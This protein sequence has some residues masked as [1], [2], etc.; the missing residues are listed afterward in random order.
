MRNR[1]SVTFLKN[2][3][4]PMGRSQL[5][6]TCFCQ[7]LALLICRPCMKTETTR[8]LEISGV[9]THKNVLNTSSKPL[10]KP[11]RLALICLT[12]KMSCH[13]PAFQCTFFCFYVVVRG[14]IW[15]EISKFAVHS[16]LLPKDFGVDVFCLLNAANEQYPNSSLL[17]IIQGQS[18]F[19]CCIKELV[20]SRPSAVV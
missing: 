18:T 9:T 17:F 8:S 4:P 7:F 2:T 19:P 1:E 14:V 6:T 11:E 13:L 3:P 12:Y 5:T 10:R 15:C 16:R 20:F